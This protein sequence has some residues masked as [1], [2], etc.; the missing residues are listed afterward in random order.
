MKTKIILLLAL[1]VTINI[2]AATQKQLPI[3]IENNQSGAPITLGIPFPKGELFSVDN[4]RMLNSKG[5]EILSQTTEVTTWEPADSSIKWIWVFF[6]ADEAS[7]YTLEYGED[8]YP[9]EPESRIISA[10]NMRP[11]GGITVDTGVLKFNINK[12]GH[13]FL[14]EVFIDLNKD[15]NYSEDELIASAPED[16]RGTFLDI[17]DDS[18]IDLSKAVVNTVFREKGS[19]ALHTIFRVE[20]TYKYNEEDNNNA[21]YYYKNPCLCRSKL[22]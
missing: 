8:I 10:N 9:M 7:D 5:K 11:R 21:P 17:L 2:H 3:K 1:I 6:F 12:K 14:D 16:Y 20:G 19:G 22:Y 13:G 15:K 4:V 18:G